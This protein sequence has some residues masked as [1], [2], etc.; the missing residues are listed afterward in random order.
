[1]RE[2]Q[3]HAVGPPTTRWADPPAGWECPECGRLGGWGVLGWV[4]FGWSG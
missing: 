1:M 2:G 4:D 3:P